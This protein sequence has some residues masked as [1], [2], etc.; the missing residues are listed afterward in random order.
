MATGAPNGQPLPP[1]VCPPPPEP[2][3][4]GGSDLSLEGACPF[5]QSGAATCHAAADDFYALIR[6]LLPG[7]RTLDLYT[8]VE[9]YHGPGRYDGAQVLLVIQDGPTLYQWSN[10]RTTAIVA[11]GERSVSIPA[12]ELTTQPGQAGAGPVRLSGLIGCAGAGP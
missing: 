5:H 11:S 8:N 12:A 6:R 9:F 2:A 10:F 7:D 1:G 4:A 3:G